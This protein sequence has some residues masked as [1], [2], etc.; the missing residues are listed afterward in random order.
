[1]VGGGNTPYL[2]YWMQRSGLADRLPEL[3]DEL[4]YVGISA[5]SMV[6][7]HS[8]HVDRAELART[9]VYADDLYG[10]VAPFAAGSDRALGLTDFVVRPHLNGKDYPGLTLDRMAEHAAGLDVPL[11]AIDDRTAVRVIDVRVDVVSEGDWRLFDP[12]P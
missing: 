6:V 2:A 9:G 7:T 1:M 10:D 8:L 4:V 12:A 5:G 3:L 11:Y